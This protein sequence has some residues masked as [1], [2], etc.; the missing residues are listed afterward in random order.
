VHGVD[1]SL[2]DRLLRPAP[3]VTLLDGHPHTLAF[4]GTVTGTPVTCL[5]VSEFGQAGSLADVHRHHGL[6]AASVV[7]AALDLLDV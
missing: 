7:G 1:E 4:L 2:L 6:D 3:L 5:G